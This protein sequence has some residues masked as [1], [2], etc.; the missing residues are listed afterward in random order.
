MAAICGAAVDGNFDTRRRAVAPRINLVQPYRVANR[1]VY[2]DGQGMAPDSIF[3]CRQRWGQQKCQTRHIG[4]QVAKDGTARLELLLPRRTP[5]LASM[6][7]VPGIKT[8]VLHR[9]RS[10]R[11]DHVPLPSPRTV[12][13]L[14]ILCFCT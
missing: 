14:R 4:C 6:S 11:E 10:H 8:H 1:I 3:T 5:P 12:I 13:F 9:A 2:S 7:D